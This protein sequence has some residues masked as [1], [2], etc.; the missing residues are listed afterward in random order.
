MTWA[1][2]HQN[3]GLRRGTGSKGQGKGKGA[4]GLSLNPQIL[5][6]LADL[7]YQAITPSKPRWNGNMAKGKAQ[8]KGNHQLPVGRSKPPPAS[9]AEFWPSPKIGLKDAQGKAML[10]DYPKDPST[11]VPVLWICPPAKGG[12][13]QHHCSMS[14]KY[15]ASC[16]MKRPNLPLAT[17]STGTEAAPK[18]NPGKPAGTRRVLIKPDNEIVGNDSAMDDGE[19]LPEELLAQEEETV[20]I[21]PML[22]VARHCKLLASLGVP[23]AVQAAKAQGLTIHLPLLEESAR[24]KELA[25]A[26]ALLETVTLAGNQGCI[27]ALTKQIEGLQPKA[28]SNL[29]EA[30]VH[31]IAAALESALGSLSHSQVQAE[32]DYESTKLAINLQ[33]QELASRLA[34]LNQN[35][36]AERARDTQL[37]AD[38]KVATLKNRAT[39]PL[40]EAAAI[41]SQEE[42]LQQTAPQAFT[43]EM[44]AMVA[45]AISTQLDTV[46]ADDKFQAHGEAIRAACAEIVLRAGLAVAQ[47]AA[48]AAPVLLAAENL[49][50]GP[51]APPALAGSGAP[52]RSAKAAP[53]MPKAKAVQAKAKMTG[54]VAETNKRG[55]EEGTDDLDEEEAALVT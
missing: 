23:Q 48:P 15:C 34:H 42:G 2:F 28:P 53:T 43:H 38:I 11:K 9:L 24:V 55:Y 25:V 17:G 50:P 20:A 4:S 30:K 6:Q 14:K 39:A 51:P 19:L 33:Q 29:T 16:N 35:R 3:T 22:K 37:H 44:N 49:D 27:L 5:G 41:P 12:C 54:V 36:L 32:A 46:C 7:L 13:G 26:V 52:S 40:G 8:G 10:M 47:H 21:A 45:A 31:S 18:P 1:S